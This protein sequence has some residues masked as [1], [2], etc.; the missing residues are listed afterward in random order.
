MLRIALPVA[1]LLAPCSPAATPGPTAS[2]APRAPAAAPTDRSEAYVPDRVCTAVTPGGESALVI[3]GCACA[4]HL[5]CRATVAGNTIDVAARTGGDAVC[6]ECN[7]IEGTCTLGGLAA[8]T[9]LTVMVDGRAV[10]ELRTDAAGHLAAGL[11]VDASA[12]GPG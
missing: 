10:T 2:A 7:L 4:E 11:C 1:L 8:D 12:P 5:D 9:A 3:H 6:D